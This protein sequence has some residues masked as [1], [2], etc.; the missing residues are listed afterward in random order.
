MCKGFDP[1]KSGAAFWNTLQ[2]TGDVL[3]KEEETGSREL[4][5][6]VCQRMDVEAGERKS[7]EFSLAW[8]MPQVTFGS[9]ESR[10]YLR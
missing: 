9:E 6:A 1:S 4:A 10:M 3:E 5:V 7:I 2:L 8:D